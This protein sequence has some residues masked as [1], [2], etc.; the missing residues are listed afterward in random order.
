MMRV[1]LVL[2]I[3]LLVTMSTVRAA[4]TLP[5][6]PPPPPDLIISAYSVVSPAV[7]HC[8]N[9]TIVF[10]VTEA[11]TGA[12]PAAPYTTSHTLNGVGICS[13]QRPGLAAGFSATFT[14]TCTFWNANCDCGHGTG[15]I[16]FFGIVDSLNAV[17]ETNESNNQSVTV[18]Q[19]IACP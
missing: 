1:P 13:F 17:P 5:F 12:G 14:D 10:S 18:L 19:P 11:N 16:P 7:S 2:S 9:Q 4:K 6:P 8:G 15:T 3:A